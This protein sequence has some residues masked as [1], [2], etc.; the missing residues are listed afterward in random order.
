MLL[1]VISV[2][3][4]RPHP[5]EAPEQRMTLK[6][7]IQTAEL[8][9]DPSGDDRVMMLLRLQG[10]S[11]G[12]PRRLLLPFELLLAHEELDVDQMA[13]RAFR[14]ECQP[15]AN[16]NGIATTIEVGPARVLRKPEG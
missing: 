5:P 14:A 9:E 6:G 12:Q 8:V 2:K 13:G 4:C 11:P 16:G 3:I 1:S 15:D 7:F 10:V